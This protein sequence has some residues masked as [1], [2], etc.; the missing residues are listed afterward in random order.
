MN[1]IVKPNHFLRKLTPHTVTEVLGLDLMKLRE[2][3]GAQIQRWE[4]VTEAVRAADDRTIRDPGY[5]VNAGD[6]IALAVPEPEPA[7]PAWWRAGG[8]AG[9]MAN[10]PLVSFA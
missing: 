3:D 2:I 5:R 1:A 10:A 6:A 7:A 4:D 9:I 8:C